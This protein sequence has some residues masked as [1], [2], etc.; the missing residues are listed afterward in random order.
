[1]YIIPRCITNLLSGG[2]LPASNA[3]DKEITYEKD[4]V[5]NMAVLSVPEDT[6]IPLV[7]FPSS[8]TTVNITF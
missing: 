7:T 1:M 2:F 6:Q 8:R 5:V 4:C 3:S